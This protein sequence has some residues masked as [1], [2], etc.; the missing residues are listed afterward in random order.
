MSGFLLALI[1]LQIPTALQQH[2][3]VVTGIVRTISGL[4]IEGARVAVSPAEAAV[5]D[6]LL[7]SIGQSDKEGR[8]RLENVSPGRYHVLFGSSTNPTYHPGVEA[9][10]GATTVLVTG[11]S[12]TTVS[13]M[14]LQRTRVGGRVVDAGTGKGRHIERLTVCCDAGFSPA[15]RVN[16]DGTFAFFLPSGDMMLQASDPA[17]VTVGQPLTVG[18]EDITDLVVPV[19]SALVFE[20]EILDRLGTPVT[21]VTARMHNSRLIAA[22]SIPSATVR[23]GRLSIPR[24]VPGRYT[25]EIVAAGVHSVKQEIELPLS[26]ETRLRV[27]LPFTQIAGRVVAADGTKRSTVR[28]VCLLSSA[29]D[30]G[31]SY[32]FPD[33]N[34]RFFVLLRQGEYRISTDDPRHTLKSI[35]VGDKEL[36]NQLLVFDGNSLPEVLITIE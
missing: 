16:E 24:L 21:G 9:T 7:E 3:G 31:F 4:P 8:Y 2:T 6:S 28:M 25:L 13:D 20:A 19:S 15:T 32:S 26:R 17:I 10:A 14:T 12:P 27:E 30:A 5:A 36:K 34:G 18:K 33:A 29:L 11:G 23:D 22:A 1:I 35:V